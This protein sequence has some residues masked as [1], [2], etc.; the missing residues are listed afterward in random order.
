MTKMDLSHFKQESTMVLQLSH[1]M[2]F[3]FLSITKYILMHYLI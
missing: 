2:Y 1:K 3:S